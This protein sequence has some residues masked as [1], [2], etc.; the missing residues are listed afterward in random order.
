MSDLPEKGVER[1]ESPVAG[2]APAGQ[3][4]LD[5]RAPFDFSLKVSVPLV[6]TTVVPSGAPAPV[7]LGVIAPTATPVPAVSPDVIA[8][9]ATPVPVISPGV[10]LPIA[11]PV[12]LTPTL[13]TPPAATTVTTSTPAVSKSLARTTEVKVNVK[14]RA[15]PKPPKRRTG[16]LLLIMLVLMLAL[17]A[18]A[19]YV[20][21]TRG[22]GSAASNKWAPSVQPLQKFVEATMR[23]PFTKVVPVVSLSRAEYEA[24]LGNFALQRVPQDAKGAYSGL[25][26]L[27]LLDQAPKASDAGAFVAATRTAFYDPQTANVYQI[28]GESGT[29]HDGNV[30]AALAVALIDQYKSWSTRIAK[31]SP[32]QRLGYLSLI[33]GGGQ[34]V[35]LAKSEA[36]K[37][38]A[39]TYSDE[40]NKRLGSRSGLGL[41]FTPWLV[42]VFDLPIANGVGMVTRAA[43]G[44]PID[45]VEVPTSDA[46]VLDA[47]R[48]I[49]ASAGATTP[50]PSTLG[51]YAWYSILAAAIG[52]DKAF[53]LASG[54]TGD[55]L[56]YVDNKGVGCI[57][58]SVVA[59]D[60]ASHA[61]LLAGLQEWAATRPE[62]ATTAVNGV[63][64]VT[65]VTA[66]DPSGSALAATAQTVGNEF[67]FRVVKE[68]ILLKQLSVLGMGLV[69]PAVVCAINSYR[70][71]GL[72][73]WETD[74]ASFGSKSFGAISDAQ[75]NSLQNLA[76]VCGQ[77]S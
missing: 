75:R 3:Q 65:T 13:P 4:H 11:A 62:S 63:A 19:T 46:A 55:S 72:N 1:G 33:E 7:S 5:R 57:R 77:A 26:S 2:D 20:V 38:F 25:R 10:A 39:A 23:H 74:Q 41:A 58:A 36:D 44:D 70:T 54:W 45:A 9:T 66:C 17:S 42:G 51:M 30:M 67:E 16:V 24:K 21:A 27:G 22:K 59:K 6:R 8:P 47:S 60:P 37:D 73:G 31:L 32:A 29:Y 49:P 53:V 15:E 76:V 56:Q 14:P 50:E 68:Q 52:P 40:Y 12:P 61:A 34:Y 64:T 69:A 48:G 28:E 18:A 43:A 71:D 35:V